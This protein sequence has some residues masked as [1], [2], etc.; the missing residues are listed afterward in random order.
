MK[1]ITIQQDNM[2]CQHCFNNVVLAISQIKGIQYLD[3]N[4]VEK[5]INIKY[6]DSKLTKNII[7]QSINKAII[8]GKIN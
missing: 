4:M 3:I 5:T 8:T 7:K 1:S 6:Q 2:Y